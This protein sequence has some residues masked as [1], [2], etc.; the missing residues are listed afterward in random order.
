LAWGVFLV[1]FVGLSA[2]GAQPALKTLTQV[3]EALGCTGYSWD[4]DAVCL[5]NASHVV[6][7]YQGRRKA[8]VNDVV[9]WLNAAPDGNVKAGDWRMAAL[10]LDFLLLSVLPKDC[11]AIKPLRVMLDAGHGGMDD[12]ASSRKP[13]VAEKKLTLDLVQ[14][15]GRLL[16]EMGMQVVYTRTNDVAVA[17]DARSRAARRTSADV[18][19]SVHANFASNT[20]ACGPETYIVTPA[21]F[22]G[23]SGNSQPRGTQIGNANDFHST[24]LGYSIH[25]HLVQVDPDMPDRGL[26][27]Q[28]FFVLREVSCP[29]VLVEVGFLSNRAEARKMLTT[30]WKDDCA[31]AIMRGVI[32][33]ARKVDTL[34]LAVDERRQRYR[35]AKGQVETL[36]GENTVDV[37]ANPEASVTQE[38][39][40]KHDEEPEPPLPEPED[41]PPE[42]L[43][44]I[45]DFYP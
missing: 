20:D 17:L 31:R 21:G 45:F 29:S 38:E 10:D 23:T 44:S 5:S 15:V 43:K 13:A 16:E 32:E 2:A 42:T 24:L 35:T 9:V 7:F 26:K 19:V 18:F 4:G 34:S 1:A 33:Y 27:R 6:R 14:R 8:E 22:A 40:V 39:P 41:E 28:S 11:N 25:K 37:E 36:A 12:G 3:Q 30:E